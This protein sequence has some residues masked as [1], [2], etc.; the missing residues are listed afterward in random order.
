MTLTIAAKPVEVGVACQRWILRDTTVFLSG[1]SDASLRVRDRSCRVRKCPDAPAA[2]VV[3][4]HSNL[5]ACRTQM[6]ESRLH[7]DLIGSYRIQIHR[8]KAVTMTRLARN[9]FISIV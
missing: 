8:S 6:L 2:F 7:V 9:V 3:F 1:K 4:R 5:C